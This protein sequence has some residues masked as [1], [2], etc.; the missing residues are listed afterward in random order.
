MANQQ[1]LIERTKKIRVMV[2]DVDGVLTDGG[3]Y[4]S[5]DGLEIKRFHSRDGLGIR[6][7]QNSGVETAIITGRTSEV[8]RLRAEELGIEHVYQ[9]R[10][11]K[12]PALEALAEKLSIGLDNFAY[13]GDDLVDLPVL[14]RVG[15]ALTVAQAHH[16]VIKRAHWVSRFSGGNGAAREACELIMQ[17]QCTWDEAMSGFLS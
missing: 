10:K 13:M 3:L 2:F 11:N 9:G 12:V 7:L 17:Y 1:D 15:L 14:T 5:D 4:R 8:V 16:E 6:L